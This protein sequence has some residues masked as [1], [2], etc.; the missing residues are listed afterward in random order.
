MIYL[1]IKNNSYKV[2]LD[3]INPNL[4]SEE[5]SFKGVLNKVISGSGVTSNIE[6]SCITRDMYSGSFSAQ[7][8][9]IT[10]STRVVASL[11]AQRHRFIGSKITGPGVN[12]PT[13]NWPDGAPVITKTTVNPNVLTTGVGGNTGTFS[14]PN[15]E[16]IPIKGNDEIIISKNDPSTETIKNNTSK[17]GGII[18]KSSMSDTTVT[19]GNIKST[20]E[21]TTITNKSNTTKSTNINKI[22]V[23]QTESTIIGETQSTNKNKSV[24]PSNTGNK[25][26]NKS[27]NKSSENSKNNKNSTNY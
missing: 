17:G 15:D 6:G 5:K 8:A 10:A 9:R 20:T 25:S 4:I 1:S 12:I 24:P 7:P 13:N 11:G 2:K 26:N 22:N 16:K 19:T 18:N 14:T 23:S 3:K 27:N 21:P